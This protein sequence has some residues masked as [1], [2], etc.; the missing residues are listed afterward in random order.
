MNRPLLNAA[1]NQPA[2]RPDFSLEQMI[3][4]RDDGVSVETLLDLIAWSL[5]RREH[6]L[7]SVT[8]ASNWVM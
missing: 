5:E 1:I 2:S 7:P 6:A 8:S 3:P 4:L